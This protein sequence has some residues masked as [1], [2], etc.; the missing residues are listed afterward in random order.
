MY[1]C[2]IFIGMQ[3]DLLFSEL[4]FC[5]DSTK[6]LFKMLFSEFWYKSKTCSKIYKAKSDGW[7][8]LVIIIKHYC[9]YGW[10]KT[11]QNETTGF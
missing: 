2:S 9:F 3:K 6:S 8:N 4:S 7:I 1:T 11:Y 10:F 5:P